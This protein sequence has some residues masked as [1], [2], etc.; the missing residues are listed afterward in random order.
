MDR[1]P[2][3]LPEIHIQCLEFNNYNQ[4]HTNERSFIVFTKSA[5]RKFDCLKENETM[6]NQ[7][8][9]ETTQTYK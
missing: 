2:I 6:Y 1:E 3:R 8:K 7:T 9:Q 4:Q 5:K